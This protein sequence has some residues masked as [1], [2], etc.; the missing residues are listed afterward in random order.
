MANRCSKVF[1]MLI[2]IARLFGEEKEKKRL[3]KIRLHI[4]DDLG[5]AVAEL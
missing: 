2:V 5:V 4:F 3:K 1:L